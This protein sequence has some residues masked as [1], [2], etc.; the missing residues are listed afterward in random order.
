VRSGRLVL[1]DSPVV[2]EG[3]EVPTH[4][5]GRQA[6]QP[7]DLGRGDGTVL[8]DRGEDTLARA[9]LVGSDKHHTIVT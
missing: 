5:G 4:R 7:P 9:L 2:S 3:V 6:E 8:G 1:L